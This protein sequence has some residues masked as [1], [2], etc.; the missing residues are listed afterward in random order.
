[1]LTPEQI[2]DE[3]DRLEQNGQEEVCRDNPLPDPD[4]G[5][6]FTC[7]QECPDGGNTSRVSPSGT[8]YGELEPI[9]QTAPLYILFAEY[10]LIAY[11]IH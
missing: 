11:S 3:R 7:V 10:S 5:T 1:M 8:C 2:D 4:L 9:L 6:S